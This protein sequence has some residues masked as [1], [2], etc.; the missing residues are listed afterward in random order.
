MRNF[1][2][3]FFTALILVA[4]GYGIYKFVFYPQRYNVPRENQGT[5]NHLNEGAAEFGKVGLEISSK[6]GQSVK[7]V[8]VNLGAQPGA[9]NYCWTKTN[10]NGVAVFDQ[11]PVGDYSIYFNDTTLPEALGGGGPTPVLQIKVTKG[12]TTEAGIELK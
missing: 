12:V 6:S 7:D 3:G 4:A 8:E 2:L 1:I 11:V 9:E 5:C 10:E